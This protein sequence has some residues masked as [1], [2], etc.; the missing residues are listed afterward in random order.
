MNFRILTALLVIFTFLAYQESDAQFGFMKKLKKK[1]E[2]KVEEEVEEG[3][4]EAI[5]GES[6]EEESER[7]VNKGGKNVSKQS[8]DNKTEE[9]EDYN[10][11]MKWGNYDFVPGDK[12]IFQDYFIDEEVGEFPSRWDIKSGNCEMMYFDGQ[13]VIGFKANNTYIMPLM[14]NRESDYMPEKF[15][16][17]FDAYFQKDEYNQRYYVHFFDAKKQ[18]HPNGHKY[19]EFF[20]SMAECGEFEGMYPGAERS[21]RIDK[22]T[23]RHISISFNKRSLKVY[24]DEARI[25]NIPNMEFN[26]TGFTIENSNGFDNNHPAVIKNIRIAEGGQKLY[27]RVKTDGKIVTTGIKFESGKAEILPISMGV[28]KKIV[29][30]MKDDASINFSIEGHTDSD[31]DDAMNQTLSEQRAAA[32]KTKFIELGIAAERL[33]TKGWGETKPVTDNS[34]PEAKANNRRVEFIKF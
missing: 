17:E 30:I 23:W 6:E 20:V 21:N 27:K 8:A 15:T 5:E 9:T 25:L 26:P 14:K 18:R 13:E 29:K 31:G 2:E 22:N 10:P 32:V 7:P 11:E 3:I 16:I 33:K 12:V 24:I 1:A 19:V 28:I 4:E 34:T